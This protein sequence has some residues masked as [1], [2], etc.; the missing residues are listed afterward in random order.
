VESGDFEI[1]IG[2]SSR[3]IVLSETVHIESGEKMPYV[4]T[5]NSTVGDLLDI[6]CAKKYLDRIIDSYMSSIGSCSDG[7]AMGESTRL[8]MEHQLRDNPL[9][10]MV[11]F[12]DGSISHEDIAEIIDNINR[13]MQQ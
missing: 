3:D 13:E 7:D 5:E 10:V 11:S 1:M 9:R 2:S 8:M 6:E 12:S 4:C